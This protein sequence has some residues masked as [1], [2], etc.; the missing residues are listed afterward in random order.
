M[1]A[2]LIAL[3]PCMASAQ[4]ASM[5]PW[6]KS[7]GIAVVVPSNPYAGRD[8]DPMVVP[9][10][11]YEGERFFFR[12][13]IAGVR[14]AR[15]GEFQIDLLARPRFS[16]YEAKDSAYLEGMDDRRKS[17]DAG[18]QFGWRRGPFGA[19]ASWM[20]DVLGYSGGNEISAEVF[21]PIPAGPVRLQASVG[22]QRQ[23]SPLTNYS[24]GVRKSEATDS[25]PYY[26]PGSAVN[27]YLGLQAIYNFGRWTAGAIARSEW[28]DDGIANSPIV[29]GDTSVGGVLTIAR[30]F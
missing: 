11:G 30:R 13:I 5:G 21:A 3:L 19:R 2:A 24:F 22:A 10:I 18:V 4:P 8:D 15:P 6:R 12:G 29:E 14:V 9:A 16:G 7:A 28:L 23:S 20:A 25:R 17:A 26:E 1:A 27:P